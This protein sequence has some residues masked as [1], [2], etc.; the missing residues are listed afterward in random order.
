MCAR[1][2]GVPPA[3]APISTPAS[4]LGTPA[5]PAC[6]SP[7]SRRFCILASPHLGWTTCKSYLLN[8]PDAETTAECRRCATLIFSVC[9]PPAD[10]VRG[11][12]E[13]VTAR[14]RGGSRFS[15]NVMNRVEFLGARRPQAPWPRPA[16]FLGPQGQPEA[17]DRTIP[18]AV[19]P[20]ESRQ[21]ASGGGRNGRGHE[22]GRRH[23]GSAETARRDRG[24]KSGV[25]AWA[26]AVPSIRRL[27]RR[28][29]SQVR[30]QVRG[31]A[32]R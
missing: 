6:L 19:P 8:R 16:A 3:C 9:L 20:Q 10:N 5:L 28:L 14:F 21:E 29:A 25:A 32:R 7:T 18:S 13:A 31:Q 4:R 23:P 27:L 26:G 11:R 15:G 17:L 12:R 1:S 22:L 30:N 2:A 24:R